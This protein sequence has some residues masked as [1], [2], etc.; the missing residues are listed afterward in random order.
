MS[1]LGLGASDLRAPL[2]GR[3]PEMQSLDDALQAMRTQ[4]EPR[5]VTILGAAGVGK[6]RLVHDFL[7]KLRASRDS[8]VRV[9]RGSARGAGDSFAIF[10]SILRARFGLVEGMDDGAAKDRVRAQVAA[11]LDD[12]KVGDVVYYLGQ[13]LYLDF[14]ESPLTKAVADDP[15]ESR[16]LR[17]SVIRSFLEADANKQPLCL[18]FD[19]LQDAHGD[20]LG[21]L[22]FLL[23]NLSGPVLAICA[24]RNEL[25]TRSDG[26]RKLGGAKHAAVELSPLNEH[27]AN[28]MMEALLAPCGEPPRQ[29]VDA[30]CQLAGGNPR[31][32][33]QMVRIF[34]DTGVVED[35][36]AL[37]ETPVWQVHLDKLQTVR[38]PLTVDDAVQARIA[39]LAPTH[40]ELLEHSAAIG[41]VFW[42]GALVVL[43]RIDK[44]PP[45]LWAAADDTDARTLR[46]HLQELVDRDYVLRLPDS[47]FPGDEEYVFKHNL[48]RER[49]SR[50][51]SP[52]V[53]K[54]Y[55]QAIAD[56]LEHQA[57]MRIHEEYV[58]MLA[59]HR[60][61]AGSQR[62]AA[63]AYVEAGDV[64]RSRYAFA[65]AIENIIRAN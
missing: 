42:L 11:V 65:K 5:I 48:E 25:E 41:S 50:L 2:V 53:A 27:D 12:R 57:D 1:W 44:T 46:E 26:W 51:T 6:S 15:A 30:A 45:E 31:L 39:A 52:S 3:L 23:D 61:A 34:H 64:A 60:E 8:E 43:H 17:R 13:L 47:S 49:V 36:D 7:G 54:R 4:R 24:G 20:S 22:G 14:E 37:A 63:V 21:L 18:V 55:H 62:Q 38:L 33:E 9:F 19:D 32:L 59:M 40:R 10:A 29:L 35:E 28:T 16:L 56:W 58:A